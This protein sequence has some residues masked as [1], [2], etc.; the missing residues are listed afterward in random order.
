M[1][2]RS[3]LFAVFALSGAGALVVETV[4]MRWMQAWFG[5]TAP[6]TAAIVTA[7]FAGS[8]LGAW[9][10]ARVV[11]R[12]SPHEALRLYAGA[13]VVVALAAL[14]T[15]GLLGAGST[16]LGAVYGDVTPWLLHPIRFAVALVATLPAAAA[17]G[18]TLPFV[19][20]AVVPSPRAIGSA[21]S[22][23]YAANLAGAVCGVAL[24]TWWGP[25]AIGVRATYGVG[26]GLALSAAAGALLV[27]GGVVG[28]GDGGAAAA[29]SAEAAGSAAGASS[30]DLWPPAE[31][32]W[33][34]AL[35]GFVALAAQVLL[36]RAVALVVNQSV[37]AFGAVLIGVLACL[38]TG[39]VIVAGL[40]ASKRAGARAI[41]GWACAAAALGFGLLPGAL[42]RVTGGFGF[43]GA[44]DAGVPYALVVLATVLLAA[45][46]ALLAA[47][48][49]WPAA[50]ALAGDAG[51]TC[52]GTAGHRVGILAAAN[53][54]GAVAAGL[55]TPFVVLPVLGPWGGFVVVAATSGLAAVVLS[56]DGWLRPAVVGGG[57][58][59]IGLAANPLALPLARRAGGERVL[60]E[61]SGA[62]GTV[63]V[64]ERDG[65]RL[66]RLDGHY[67]LGGTG[68]LVHEARQ[69]HVPLLLHARPRRVAFVGTATGIT[70]GA[71]L[72]HDVEAITL[73]E[74]VP[75]VAAA[76]AAH[77]AGEN[78]GVYDSER[79]HVVVDDARNYWRHTRDRYDVIVADLF[80]P[81]QA[82][83]GAL[84]AREHFQAMR[85]RLAPGGLVAQWLPIYQLSAAE[86]RT[87]VAT[88]TDVFP[89]AAVFR[90]DFYA[91]FPIVALVGWRDRPTPAAEVAGAV[92]RLAARGVGDRWLTDPIAFHALYL[93]PLDPNASVGVTR[94]LLDRPWIE[95]QAA[96]RHAGGERGK[97]DALRGLGW[98]AEVEAWEAAAPEPDPLYPD[99]PAAA[100][101]ARVGGDLLQRAGA[102]WMAGRRAEAAGA[103]AAA[104][105]ALPPS[106]VADAPADASATDVWREPR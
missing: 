43:V 98:M 57:A 18:A 85:D 71:A 58:L 84:Y 35:S 56:P 29:A 97:V 59:V 100:R 14:A 38:A 83:T 93:A 75:E 74:I 10:G 91:T 53:T 77:F 87:I 32:V 11:R 82:A 47:G 60:D 69:G 2:G 68:E 30:D 16:L 25:P 23:L 3:P 105:E 92:R 28:A 96:A 48:C 72:D 22:A 94:N 46:P 86:L 65:A 103:L 45:G 62:A 64:V 31:A 50:L 104:A 41:A 101:R 78:R 17:Y 4:W 51:G 40:R 12:A 37:T 1:R 49:I 102:L 63:A 61:R 66:L 42:H 27:G 26:I 9:F 55:V 67:A 24:A 70:A 99:L 6:A 90:G 79:S 95:Y 21:G 19:T 73:V 8:A 20:A 89:T 7:F 44:S 33:L 34:S 39:A 5:A 80:V 106:V 76:G 88:F 54:L 52:A 81:W 36:V 13:E 15:P